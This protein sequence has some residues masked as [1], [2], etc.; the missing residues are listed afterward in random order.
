MI[1]VD[2]SALLA[3]LLDE[4]AAASCQQALSAGDSLLISAASLTEILI[5]AARKDVLDAM[6]A[7]LATLQPTI[8]PLTKSRARAAAEAYRRWGK[9]FH[10]AA[11][12][13]GDCFAYA[14]AREHNA[15]LLYVG[16]DF[17]RTDVM[18]ALP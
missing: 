16:G 11:L 14:L 1:V 10:P 6:Q 17:A 2:S 8:V 12:N 9:G 13:F 3:I 18:P 4:E 5:V 7:M 15:P